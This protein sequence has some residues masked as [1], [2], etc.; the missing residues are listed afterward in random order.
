MASRRCCQRSRQ[1]PQRCW[2]GR[3][4]RRNSSP[5]RALVQQRFSFSACLHASEPE[6][7][8]PRCGALMAAAK[9]LCNSFHSSAALTPLKLLLLGCG[10]FQSPGHVSQSL[11][12][13]GQPQG[14]LKRPLFFWA[15]P[16]TPGSQTLALNGEQM[17]LG[18]FSP[19]T[20]LSAF[21]HTRAFLLEVG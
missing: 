4:D 14:L 20:L 12:S 3:E 21:K 15:T 8:Q 9:E 11:P 18:N 17:I 16:S 1:D 19:G 10:P 6:P 13:V 5:T 7:Q 2:K